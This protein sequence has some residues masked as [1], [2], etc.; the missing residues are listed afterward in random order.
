MRPEVLQRVRD[1]HPHKGNGLS[2]ES[3]VRCLLCN[4]TSAASVI[5]SHHMVLCC[6]AI[7]SKLAGINLLIIVDHALA[8]KHIVSCALL[9]ALL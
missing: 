4:W 6:K 3:R 1:N 8:Q 7:A 5:E 2:A 9:L